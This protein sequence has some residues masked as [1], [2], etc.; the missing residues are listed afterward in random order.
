MVEP[1][2]RR[3]PKT[4]NDSARV[5]HGIEGVEPFD[6]FPDPIFRLGVWPLVNIYPWLVSVGPDH[7]LKP[8]AEAVIVL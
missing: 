2:E 7:Q 8:L 6:D 4:G 3:R 5:L 1:L